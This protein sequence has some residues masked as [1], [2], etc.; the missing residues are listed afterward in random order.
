MPKKSKSYVK[1]AYSTKST[2]FVYLFFS[3]FFV[4]CCSFY[5][6]RISFIRI[7]V[8]VGKIFVL[9][10]IAGQSAL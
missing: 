7:D 6:T 4:S 2:K 9:G 10:V 1:F 5:R 8:Y 3:F